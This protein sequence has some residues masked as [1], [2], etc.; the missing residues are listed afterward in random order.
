MRT[1]IDDVRFI[2]VEIILQRAQNITNMYI[3]RINIYYI[4]ILTC[5]KYKIPVVSDN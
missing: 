5:I 2:W 3:I 1:I 4:N